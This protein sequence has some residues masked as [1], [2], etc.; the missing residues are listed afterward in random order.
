[1]SVLEFPKDFLWGYATAAYQIEGAVAEDGKGESIWDRFTHTPDKILDGKNGDITCDHYHLYKEDVRIMKELG[2]KSYR[3]SLSWPRIIPGGKGQIN[4]KGVDFYKRLLTSLHENGIVPAVTL[5]HWD[6]PQKLQDIGGWANRDTALYYEEYCAK[7]YQQL[8]DLIPIWITH[9]EPW[10]VSFLSNWLGIHAP[11]NKD[12]KTAAQVSY[13]ILYSHGLGVRAFRDSG[14]KGEIGITM[15]FT[16]IYPASEKEEDIKAAQRYD[17]YYNRWFLD[18]VLKGSFPADM[19]EHYQS[20]GLLPEMSDQDLELMSQPLDF[21][22]VNYY[23]SNLIKHDSSQ[24]PLET[25]VVSRNLPVTSCGWEVHPEGMYDLLVRIRRDYGDI[26]ILITENGAAYEDTV[27]ESGEVNDPARIDYLQK[28]Y[29]QT[30]R[31]IQDGVNI[32]GYYVWSYCDNFEWAEGFTKRFG[33]VYVD[34]PTRKRIVKSSG[35][36]FRDVMIRNAVEL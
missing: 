34:Y 6:L 29:V 32:T 16:Q 30:H 31:A 4:Q 15:N 27:S 24:Q 10:C 18:P 1:M 17:G 7:M 14:R 5:Y 26:K 8:G 12:F 21:L 33:L 19:S 13:N 9:N 22:G 25:S 20:R 2:T 36:W 11:G 23:T 3:F 28:H 35:R